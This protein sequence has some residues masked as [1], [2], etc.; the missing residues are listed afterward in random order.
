MSTSKQLL[1]S[2]QVASFVAHGS[3]RLDAVVPPEMNEQAIGVFDAGIPEVPFGT[4]VDKAFPEGPSPA[5]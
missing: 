5:G 1:N 3:L 2:A 4:P